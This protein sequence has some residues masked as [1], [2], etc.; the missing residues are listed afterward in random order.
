MFIVK[1][2]LGGALFALWLAYVSTSLFIAIPLIWIALSLVT[3]SSAYA[4]Q[5]PAIFRKKQDGS[6]PFYIRWFSIQF[7]ALI[8][9][10]SVGL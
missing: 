4:L 1:Y 10:S 3:V 9:S 5:K 6:I 8:K 7:T 2:Y